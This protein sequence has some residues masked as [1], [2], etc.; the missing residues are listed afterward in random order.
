MQPPIPSTISEANFKSMMDFWREVSDR[1][2]QRIQDLVKELVELKTKEGK[3]QEDKD[4]SKHKDQRMPTIDV[5]DVKRPEEYDG[6][7]KNFLVWYQR[8]KGLLINRHSSWTDV[9]EAVEAFQHRVIEN[10][11]GKH[12]KFKEKLPQDSLAMDDPDMYARQLTSYLGSYTKGLLHSKV[13]KTQSRGS[14]E[15]LRDLVHKGRNRNKNRLLS[16]KASVL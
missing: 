13:M 4:K 3:E 14:F 7:E 11:D 12:E 8:F 10:E 6:D 9:F 2:E 5:K 1:Q 16:I 15:L